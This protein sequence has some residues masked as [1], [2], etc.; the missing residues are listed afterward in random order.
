[1]VVKDKIGRRRYIIVEN[2]E[3]LD[4]V[5]R[6]IRKIDNKARIITRIDNFSIIFCRHW[7]KERVIEILK[8]RGIN[9]YR[10][11]GTI[12]KAKEFIK[13]IQGEDGGGGY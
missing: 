1:M 10:T 11:A 6:D 4:S 5:M 2:A 12:K 9:T 7:Y 3:E 13:I 8:S